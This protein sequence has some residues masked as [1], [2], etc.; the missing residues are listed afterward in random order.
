M[1][2]KNHYIDNTEFF[3]ELCLWQDF[4]EK[5]YW[6]NVLDDGVKEAELGIENV[7]KDN[8]DFYNKKDYIQH[9]KLRKITL[10]SVEKENIKKMKKEVKHR[11]LLINK[12]IQEYEDRIK[13]CNDKIKKVKLSGKERTKHRKVYNNIGIKVNLII[14]NFSIKPQYRNYPFLEDMKMLAMEHCIKGLRTFDRNRKNSKPFTYF[15]FA[16]WRAFLQEIKKEKDLLKN[17]FNYV[18]NF[19]SDSMQMYDY[20]SNSD[21]NVDYTQKNPNENFINDVEVDKDFIYQ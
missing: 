14:D 10:T 17:K 12:R 9:T 1:Y 16:V 11:E 20:N 7:I 2:K 19:V 4:E 3:D 13:D 5:V 18:K 21:T 15:T 8:E 6:Y